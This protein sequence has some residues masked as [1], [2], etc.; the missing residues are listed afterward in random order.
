[1]RIKI[2]SAININGADSNSYSQASSRYNNGRPPRSYLIDE[3]PKSYRSG[4]QDPK[5]ENNTVDDETSVGVLSARKAGLLNLAEK[6]G[7]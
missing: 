3:A 2:A 4:Y 5:L 1:M 7:A 6:A